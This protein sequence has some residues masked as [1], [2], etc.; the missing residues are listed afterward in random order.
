LIK[1]GVVFLLAQSPAKIT[2]IACILVTLC[3]KYIQMRY[4]D[5][6][7]IV[8]TLD[9]GGT[10]FVFS[11]VRAEQEI[12]EPFSLPARAGTLEDV[13]ITIKNGFEQTKE[14]L[15]GQAS[16]ISFAFPGPADYE[17]GIIGDLA[18][19]PVFRGGVALGPFLQE[20]FGMPV[21][22]NNDGDLFAYGEAISGLLPEVNRW[23]SEAGSPKQYQNLL[24]VTFGT[25]FGGGIVLRGEL[26]LGDN[27]AAGEI[28]RL[29]NKIHRGMSVEESV[30]IRAIRRVYARECGMAPEEAPEP[31]I[32]YEIGMG[33]KPG[34][35]QA[36]IM[37]WHELAIAAGNA[38]AD[39]VSLVDGLVVVGGGLSGA[40]PLFLD[41]L[42]EEINHPYAT[43]GNESLQRLEIS[44]YNLENEI[45][46]NKFIAGENR[47]VRIPFSS[48]TIQYD[49]DH[50]SGI[51]IS[52]LGTS[53]AVAVGAYNYALHRL[54]IGKKY[55]RPA[56]L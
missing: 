27:S 40:Y 56:G 42:V 33:N 50:R 15:P 23:L 25:G 5:D 7:R 39:T 44:F 55:H 1:F 51:G 17:L 45:Q 19:L 2:K 34:N 54:D 49:P 6:P 21:F 22:I 31:R 11:A 43:F 46:R 8:M 52:R 3:P 26:F 38:I 9:A 16:A 14:M 13:L 47:V 4:Q 53:R 24:G 10:N 30:S 48:K 35:Q 28:N 12:I 41:R 20:Q 29:T 37:A 36:A 18:N 32:I